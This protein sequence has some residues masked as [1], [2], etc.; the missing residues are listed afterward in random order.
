MMKIKK[1]TVEYYIEKRGLKKRYIANH[2][3]MSVPTLISRINNPERFTIAELQKLA[4]ILQ[5]PMMDLFV[6]VV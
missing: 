3:G 1:E 4:G 6:D 5:I 2:M